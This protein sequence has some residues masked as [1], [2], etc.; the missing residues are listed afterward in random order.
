MEEFK[1][2]LNCKVGVQK[3]F[4]EPVGGKCVEEGM[5]GGSEGS[6]LG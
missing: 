4:L 3:A 2:V 5:D 6:S 1:D